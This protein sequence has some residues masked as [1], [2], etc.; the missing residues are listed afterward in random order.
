MFQT[1]CY[2]AWLGGAARDSRFAM[3][4]HLG[5]TFPA[6]LFLFLAGISVAIIA[7]KL[8]QKGVPARRIGKKIVTRG[9]EI[10]GLGVLFR[11]QEYVISW[12]WAPWSDLFR[13]D[14]LNTIGVSIM[15]M[16][17]MCWVVLAWSAAR[18][19][20]E[21]R[22]GLAQSLPRACRGDGNPG[23]NAHS[24]SSPGGTEPPYLRLVAAAIAA[25]ITIS[26]LTPLVWTTWRPR[27]LPWQLETYINGVHNLGSPQPWL[28]PIF[29]W[30]GF[31]FAGLALGFILV[32]GW[33][34][35][36]GGWIFPAI[37]TCGLAIVYLSKFVD[38]LRYVLFLWPMPG[39]AGDLAK[40]ASVL[41]SN[42]ARLHCLF[43]GSTSSLYMGVFTFL[44]RIV[45][46]SW[47]RQKACS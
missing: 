32:S 38:S 31:A 17:A 40:S 46:R 24:G 13:V 20:P 22:T 25:A 9:A 45:R 7:D 27:F 41:W 15:L 8:L 2:D 11:L 4:S 42:W 44:R 16:G 18:A 14:I 37:G 12:G 29:P 10:L 1:H 28:F 5:G 3:R 30:T 21:G 6:P 26:A 35:K 33:A 23:K 43:T 36:I 39:A 34:G 47:V 19:A